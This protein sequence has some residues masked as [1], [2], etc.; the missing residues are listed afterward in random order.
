VLPLGGFD[1]AEGRREEVGLRRLEE[2]GI[3][4]W[5]YNRMVTGL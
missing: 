2:A 4:S 1:E 3:A 5:F